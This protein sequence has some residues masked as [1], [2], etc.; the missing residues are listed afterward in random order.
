MH[1]FFFYFN[2]NE[3]FHLE[4]HFYILI[5]PVGNFQKKF[6]LSTV[7]AARPK[8][9]RPVEGGENVTVLENVTFNHIVFTYEG[10]NSDGDKVIFTPTGTISPFF[11]VENGMKEHYLKVNPPLDFE[12]TQNY[13]LNNI[14]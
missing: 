14:Q 12:T 13:I 10:F 7:K 8:C 5:L 9:V 4:F 1:Y 3:C 11:L 6:L 2:K